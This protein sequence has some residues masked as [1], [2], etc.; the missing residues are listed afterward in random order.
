MYNNYSEPVKKYIFSLGENKDCQK[1]KTKE[2]D[3]QNKRKRLQTE[4]YI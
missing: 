2:K 1:E 3:T 4:K